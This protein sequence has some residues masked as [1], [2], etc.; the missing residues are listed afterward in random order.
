MS[1][2]LV[3][4][5]IG[6]LKYFRVLQFFFRVFGYLLSL[7]SGRNRIESLNVISSF[8]LGQSENYI[9]Y[10]GI[11]H[12]MSDTTL[13]SICASAISTV[14]LV[15]VASY[16]TI[17]DPK[18]VIVAVILNMI[19]ICIVLHIINPCQEEEACDVNN[20][21]D[22]IIVKDS[23]FE[24]LADH[25]WTGFMIAAK[26]ITMMIGFIALIAMLNSIFS[27]MLGIT[28]QGIVGYIFIPFSWLL[29]IPYNQMHLASEIM[30]TKIITNEFVAMKMLIEN[31]ALLSQH[32]MAVISTFLV[33]F[34][35]L[36]SLGVMVGI[37]QAIDRKAVSRVSNIMFKIF[38]GA[39]FVS[40]LSASTV[41]LF[42]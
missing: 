7:I 22:R 15:I 11:L 31:S 32:T 10:K 2:I 8:V 13:Y 42:I 4:A 29:H 39:F 37:I 30:S 17:I 21:I 33:S 34:A 25:M 14:S 28:F 24:M 9:M 23:F 6:I 3:S 19:N 26:I 40:I 18:Y 1:I 27:H 36:S 20:L 16:M 5:L 38:Y 41:G 35:N 12:K